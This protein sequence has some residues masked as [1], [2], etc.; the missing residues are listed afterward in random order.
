MTVA[1]LLK[2][3]SSKEITE[4]MAFGQLEPFG[5]DAEFMGHAI[6]AKTVADVHRKQGSQPYK[7]SDFMPTLTK[8]KDQT[9]EE[10][11]QVAHMITLAMGGQDLR[12]DE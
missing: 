6:T 11:I 3:I 8:K 4:W 10:M 9:P 2:R 1:E 12:E 7:V 5:A